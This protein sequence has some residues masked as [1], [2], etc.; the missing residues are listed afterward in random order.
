MRRQVLSSSTF[1][2]NVLP[3][4][5]GSNS[6]RCKQP[7]RKQAERHTF[8]LL[9][10]LTSSTVNMVKVCS[11]ETSV[12]FYQATLQSLWFA[13]CCAYDKPANEDQKRYWRIT[14]I[15]YVKVKLH[16]STFS[17]SSSGVT[18]N[19]E[20]L[21]YFILIYF[22]LRHNRTSQCACVYR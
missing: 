22:H 19:F 10:W 1:R 13:S 14:I 7:I 21:I 17:R 6:K 2:T 18:R 9:A 5:S 12:N 16:V 15:Y 3:P 4:S 20:V 11:S 8:W